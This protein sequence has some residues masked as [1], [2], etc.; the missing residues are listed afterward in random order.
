MTTALLHIAE[1]GADE[2]AWLVNYC[3]KLC[4]DRAIADDLAQETLL[5][6]WQ[7]AER[8]PA[9]VTRRAWLAGIAHNMARRWAR[10]QQRERQEIALLED[11]ALFAAPDTITV[12]LDRQ[13]LTVLL[14]RAL[15]LLPA[16]TRAALIAHYI[17]ERPQAQIAR[18]LGMSEGALAVRLH[19]GRLALQRIL[20]PDVGDVLPM[21]QSISG[22]EA[23]PMW[24]FL[25]G[26]RHLEGQFDS[27][28]TNLRL[29]CASCGVLMDHGVAVRGAKTY[30]AAINRIIR[31]LASY[32]LPAAAAGSVVC[33]N[34]GQ[35]VPVHV[36]SN[37]LGTGK[38][39][40]LIADCACN[41]INTCDMTYIALLSPEG[42]AFNRA[43]P[44]LRLANLASVDSAYGP[45]GVMTF[46]SLTGADQFTLRYEQA[47]LRLLP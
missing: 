44:R 32:Y 3:A 13:E 4:G 29:R 47:T 1:I 42:R 23:T 19:R 31:W 6:A 21:A 34:C 12:E 45:T 25:C 9:D 5:A 14:Y 26:K 15:T 11:D 36:G 24:C 2:R 7:T 37:I 8:Q 27:A 41:A 22:W 38:A 35:T 30:G 33:F 39:P 20:A 10:Q 46:E 40:S 43:H 18:E 28:H 17:E 16:P